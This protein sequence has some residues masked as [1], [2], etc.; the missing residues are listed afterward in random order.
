[1]AMI[2]TEKQR[3]QYLVLSVFNAKV[4]KAQ[5]YFVV[6]LNPSKYLNLC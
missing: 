2:A 4:A 1:M 5:N 6:N 3:L